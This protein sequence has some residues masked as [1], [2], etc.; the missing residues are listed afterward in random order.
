M[1]DEEPKTWK[2][3]CHCGAVRF[4]VDTALSPAVRCNCSLCRRKGAIMTPPVQ[5]EH[6]R[7]LAGRESLTRYQY[8]TLTAE[9]FF[10]KHCGIYPFHHPRSDPRAYRVNIGCLED[11]DPFSLDVGMIDGASL[12]TP[13]D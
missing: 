3:S 6:F 5:P 10:C 12:S 7:L 1:Q 9:H 13:S 4:E 2:G 11:A 8:N